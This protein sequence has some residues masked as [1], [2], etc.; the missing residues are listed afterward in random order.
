MQKMRKIFEG[1]WVGREN[2]SDAEE[3]KENE[4]DECSRSSYKYE[5]KLPPKLTYD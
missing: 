2:L 3:V 4:K 1:G 5:P